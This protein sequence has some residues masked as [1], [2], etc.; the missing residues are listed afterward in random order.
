MASLVDVSIITHP[1]DRHKTGKVYVSRLEMKSRLK[2]V[3]SSCSSDTHDMFTCNIHCDTE[4]LQGLIWERS[5]NEGN[6]GDIRD[7]PE[8]YYTPVQSIMEMDHR[9]LHWAET[10]LCECGRVGL[11]VMRVD[12]SFERVGLFATSARRWRHGFRDTAI[13]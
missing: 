1:K 11:L 5:W 13:S 6:G 7:S 10:R 12:N 2:R 9:H 3:P 8:V 4:E